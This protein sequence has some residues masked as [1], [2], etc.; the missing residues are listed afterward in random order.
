MTPNELMPRILAEIEK[1]VAEVFSVQFALTTEKILTPVSFN[2]SE[3]SVASVI[4]LKDP[5]FDVAFTLFFPRAAFCSV[6]E[7][8]FGEPVTE[9]GAGNAD[10]VGE[11]LNMVYAG[12][13]KRLNESG[14][15]LQPAVPAVMWGKGLGLSMNG[16][17]RVEKLVFK[18]LDQHFEVRVAI[19]KS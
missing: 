19:R 12:A 17:D 8:M 4:N 15:S 11:I 5:A 16:F 18:T 10:A 7:T 14:L 13:R 9:I 2:E 6:V 3:E 1:A